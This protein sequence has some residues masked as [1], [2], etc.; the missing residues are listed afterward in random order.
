M[1]KRE[2][3]RRDEDEPQG[4]ALAPEVEEALKEGRE[5][6]EAAPDD[7]AMTPQR[8]AAVRRLMAEEEELRRS[9]PGF[10]LLQA[11]QQHPALRALLAA[12]EP[13]QRAWGYVRMDE[14]MRD[15][16]RAGEEDVVRRIRERQA[17]P[18]AL[19]PGAAGEAGRDVARMSA[20]EIRRIDERLRRGE[21][22]RL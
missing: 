11:V 15:A 12:G 4:A 20:Q 3:L 18:E 13:L 5:E 6:A 14:R 10:D 17:L 16:R 8:V 2:E 9:E 7:Q 1:D 21:H 19:A 22:V